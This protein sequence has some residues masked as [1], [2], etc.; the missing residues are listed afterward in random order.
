TFVEEAS[1]AQNISLLRKALGQSHED[2]TYIE[3]IPRRGYRFVA[4]VELTAAP[5][6][7]DRTGRV[8]AISAL[9][10]LLAG[11]LTVL[12]L[13]W[14]QQP[15]SEPPLRTPKTM[16]VLPFEPIG[17][18]AADEH[19]GLGLAD[20]LI[21]KLANIRE[22]TVRPT[23]S[24]RRYAGSDQPRDLLKA[25][26]EL[27]VDSV[28]EGTVQRA[29]ERV[30]VSVQLIRVRDGTPLWTGIFQEKFTD[31][32]A[33][34]DSISE[35]VAKALAL[36]LTSHERRR[37]QKRDTENVEAY[38]AY[39]K[40]RFF[41]NKRTADGFK[42][43]VDHFNHAI[44]L[45][46]LY[47]LAYAG[48]AD[49]YN[50]FNN[51]D[52]APATETGPKAKAAAL[53]ALEI[54]PELAEAH[55][56]LALVREVYDFDQIGADE[57]Y[58]KSIELNPN[59]STAHHWYGLFLV[60]MGR[61]DDAISHLR[62]AHELDP[63]SGIINVGVAWAYYFARQHDRAI[64]VSKQ[65]VDLAP[66]FWPAHLVLGWAYE[67]KGRFSE[68]RD[69]F[70]RAIELSGRNTLPLASLGHLHAVSGNES[71]ARRILAELN[72]LSRQRYI[73]PYF[74]AAIYAGLRKKEDALQWLERA[75]RERAY[76]L[77]SIQVNPWFDGL[78]QEP[79]FQDLQNR[80]GFTAYRDRF[81]RP[82]PTS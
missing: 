37:M 3:T 9:A 19:L 53:K 35:Q 7:V 68:A 27:Q 81:P 28:L 39:L 26:R 45:D 51:Y 49:C 29:G 79:R 23:S 24:V 61:T 48:L 41:W 22:V 46:P 10:A 21:T 1:L 78:R 63:L 2:H 69:E 57:S 60:Q 32:F 75:H 16:A 33:V 17:T 36:K 8:R 66:D 43:A 34:Q 67:Q 15:S 50:L 71:E 72:T 31:I 13:Y 80:L 70:T 6:V 56:S 38:E 4:P 62:R 18:T 73:S 14:Q 77:I 65:N 20:T 52:L 42:K 74:P 82:R 5:A 58:R 76:W 30:R 44:E 11:A 25:G 64:E 55:T 12:I 47:A 40:G 54:D 59:Y